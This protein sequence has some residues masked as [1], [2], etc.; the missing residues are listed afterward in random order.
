[1]MQK[2]PGRPRNA[3]SDLELVSLDE[4]LRR[5]QAFLKMD[6]PP[7]T[8]RTLQNKISKGEY[9]RYGTYHEPLLDWNEVKKHLHWRRRVS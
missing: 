9:E 8:R 1:M 4:C 7:F 5:A 3:D 2:R 6:H